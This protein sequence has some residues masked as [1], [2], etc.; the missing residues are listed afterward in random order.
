[1]PQCGDATVWGCCREV[2]QTLAVEIRFLLF[3]GTDTTAYT[4]ARLMQRLAKHPEWLDALWE[5]Q[6]RLM[7]EFGEEL[8]RRVRPPLGYR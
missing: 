8:D 6:Q 3:S 1:M 4:A 7:A 2:A 5:E